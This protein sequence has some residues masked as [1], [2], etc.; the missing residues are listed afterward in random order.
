MVPRLTNMPCSDQACGDGPARRPW[1]APCSGRGRS[2]RNCIGAGVVVAMASA[3]AVIVGGGGGPP[4]VASENLLN[5]PSPAVGLHAYLQPPE[6]PPDELRS[7]L[8][9]A[10]QAATHGRGA[11]AASASASAHSRVF[12]RDTVGLPQ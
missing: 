5:G 3:L 9:Q 8:T 11:T 1:E 7:R 6:L 4:A 10:R 2:M 12:N